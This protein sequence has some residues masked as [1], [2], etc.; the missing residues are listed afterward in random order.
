MGVCLGGSGWQVWDFYFAM[1]TDS[2]GCR[3]RT[4]G[5]TG[6]PHHPQCSTLH[7]GAASRPGGGPARRRGHVCDVTGVICMTATTTDTQ[8]LRR[9]EPGGSPACPTH[10]SERGRVGTGSVTLHGPPRSTHAAS[11]LGSA[12]HGRPHWPLSVCLVK[13]IV[14]VP[15]SCRHTSR[16]GE[17]SRQVWCGQSPRSVG[18]A[19]RGELLRHAVRACSG[20]RGLTH[21]PQAPPAREYPILLAGLVATCGPLRLPGDSLC[22]PSLPL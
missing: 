19:L 10:R 13:D 2:Q 9:A 11:V 17:C 3:G 5:P 14:L 16:C 15:G 1:T 21:P 18:R 20:A 22:G 6:A 4:A 8:R 12:S 7:A